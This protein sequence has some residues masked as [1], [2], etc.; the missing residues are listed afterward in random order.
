MCNFFYGVASGVDRRENRNTIHIHHEKLT[1]EGEGP[2]PPPPGGGSDMAA[3]SATESRPLNKY[4]K[5]R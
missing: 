1:R 2:R 4:Q 3:E 5:F